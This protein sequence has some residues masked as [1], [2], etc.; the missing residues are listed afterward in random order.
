MEGL[1]RGIFVAAVF[2]GD[3]GKPRPALVVQSDRMIE[4]PSILLA[5]LTS[6]VRSDVK[7]FR[8][9]IA[10]DETNGLRRPSQIALD[11]IAPLDHRRIGGLSGYA[12]ATT[13]LRVNRALLVVLGLI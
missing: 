11:K 3:Y 13:M 6:D 8:I 9:D 2:S 4:A 12:D 1:R 7:L 5:P 10:P